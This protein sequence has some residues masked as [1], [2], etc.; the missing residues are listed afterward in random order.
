MASS[1]VQRRN[2]DTTFACAEGILF[3]GRHTTTLPNKLDSIPQWS[4]CVLAFFTS[5]KQTPSLRRATL[6]AAAFT[7]ILAGAKSPV[8]AADISSTSSLPKMAS[9]VQRMAE[10]FRLRM[11]HL[12]TGE[13]INVVYRE[14]DTYD[15]Q[16]IAKLNHFLRD[17]RTMDDA[18]YDPKEFD[19]LHKLMARLG[20]PNGEIDIVCGYRTPQS[21]NYLRTRA[22]VTGVAQHSQHMLSKAIDIRVPG[23]STLALRN[24]AL[25]LGMG[26]VGYYPVSQFV[27]VDVGPVRQWS[28]G[29]ASERTGRKASRRHRA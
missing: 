19:L 1:G 11:R 29:G 28:F 17:H 2:C 22:A 9:P 20:K 12:H 7:F 23:V 13:T 8:K 16:G 3:R 5:L 14:G 4:F 18:D 21:N 26:G 10:T 27:H 15:Q 6:A 25:S 24:A